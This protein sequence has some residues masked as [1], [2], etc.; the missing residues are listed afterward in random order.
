MHAHT[1]YCTVALLVG[2]NDLTGVDGL[3]D[4]VRGTAVNGAADGLSGTEDLLNTTSKVLGHRLVGHLAGNLQC[5]FCCVLATESVITL[6][7]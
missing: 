2:H 1:L 4:V 5:Q 3:D 7:L 6:T